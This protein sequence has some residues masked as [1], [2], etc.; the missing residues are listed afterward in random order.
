MIIP[1]YSHPCLNFNLLKEQ[2]PLLCSWIYTLLLIFVIANVWYHS[3]SVSRHVD[4]RE[5]CYVVRDLLLLFL[6]DS[7]AVSSTDLFI[8]VCLYGTS[9]D[10]SF[11]SGNDAEISY[12]WLFHFLKCVYLTFRQRIFSRCIIYVFFF[13]F[14]VAMNLLIRIFS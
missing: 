8:D 5:W 2:S 9:K 12:I 7:R 4:L 13:I 14:K 1:E 3:E 11:C 6:F 10:R